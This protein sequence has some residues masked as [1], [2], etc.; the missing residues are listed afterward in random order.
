MSET[1]TDETAMV[2]RR[3]RK[4]KRRSRSYPLQIALAALSLFGAV[5]MLAVCIM[6]LVRPV[7]RGNEFGRN[8]AVMRERLAR[9]RKVN[10]DL[11]RRVAY[12]RTDEGAERLARKKGFHRP[13]EIV[14]LLPPS[15]GD[16]TDAWTR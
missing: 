7:T 6:W 15:P 2:R 3:N 4:K 12:L 16:P 9:Q 10:A 1:A 8:V 11:Q 14:Y 5:W 13:G